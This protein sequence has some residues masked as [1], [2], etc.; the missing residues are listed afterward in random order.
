MAKVA[1]WHLPSYKLTEDEAFDRV[2]SEVMEEGRSNS[3]V[4]ALC[5]GSAGV[6]DLDI[7]H[8]LLNDHPG[9]NDKKE[10]LGEC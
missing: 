4:C 10:R 6:P 2:L 5:S 7:S 3:E 8:A 1:P 9:E